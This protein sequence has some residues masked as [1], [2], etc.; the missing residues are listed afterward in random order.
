MFTATSA[1][2]RTRYEVLRSGRAGKRNA[3]CDQNQC[4]IH[5]FG[6][7]GEHNKRRDRHKKAVL[8]NQPLM[9]SQGGLANSYLLQVLLLGIMFVLPCLIFYFHFPKMLLPCFAATP[10]G[11]KHKK[12]HEG[13]LEAA[14][15]S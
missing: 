11:K 7:K 1:A 15:R 3:T 5:I 6:K 13:T 10:E 4:K 12:K 8:E 9:T 2:N 14:E